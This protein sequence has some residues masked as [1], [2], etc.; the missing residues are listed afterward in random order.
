MG[1][2]DNWQKGR[3]GGRRPRGGKGCSQL[4]CTEANKY[5][6]RKLMA[7]GTSA[8][9]FFEQGNQSHH[10][11]INLFNAREHNQAHIHPF[12]QSSPVL[13]RVE[14]MHLI[15][16]ERLNFYWCFPFVSFLFNFL[17][18]IFRVTNYSST[19]SCSSEPSVQ[20]ICLLQ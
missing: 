18:V 1:G 4:V 7:A 6:S 17:R 13:C 10:F 14:V 11:P 2:R 3:E 16:P 19:L 15:L 9:V 12:L 5:I 20:N 8:L